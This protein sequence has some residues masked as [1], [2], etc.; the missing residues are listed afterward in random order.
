MAADDALVFDGA[1][2]PNTSVTLDFATSQTIGQLAFINSVQAT[3]NNDG[4]RTLNIGA[5]PPTIG[6]QVGAGAKVQIVGT[7]SSAALKVQLASNVKASIAGRIELSG[8]GSTGSGHQLLSNTPGALE[9]LS[10]SYLLCGSK[11]IGF[12]FG[13]LSTGAG[14]AVF[15]SGA[16]FE[17][18]SG[19]TAFGGKTWSMAA[20]NPGSTFV[21]SATSGTLGVSNRTFGHILINTNRTSPTA[22]FGAGTLKIV[23]DLTITA[24]THP[25]NIQSIELLGNLV[26][27]GGNMTMPA[28][29]TNNGNAPQAST[30][31]IA[32]SA[33]QSISGTGT[34][35]MGATVSLT[36]N[37]A[38]GLTL[39]RPVQI[40]ANLAL[41]QGLLTTTA[42]A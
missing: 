28:V 15:R 3:L 26:L 10:G 32:G 13:E 24:G 25:F 4:P 7:L 17:Q 22:T 6:L 37:N 39:Q 34:I 41:T 35:T 29:D 19:G 42:I 1:L 18:F 40:N 23:N 14:S 30:L 33:A 36:L 27:N 21:F 8:L 12:P 9:F 16:T 20:F 5:V 31:N 2:T 38:A 11:F